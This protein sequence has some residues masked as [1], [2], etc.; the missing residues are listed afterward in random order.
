MSSGKRAAGLSH[1]ELNVSDYRASLKFYGRVLGWLGWERLSCTAQFTAWS[2][3]STKLILCPVE[4]RFKGDAFHRKRVGL[5]HVAFSVSS[6]E[7]V[8]R[9]H[10]EVLVSAAGGAGQCLYGDGPF[11]DEGYYAVYFEDPDRVKL[12]VVHAPRY[13]D[14]EAWP[15]NLPQDFET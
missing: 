7:E 4:E 15:N 11:G 5:N 14:R 10:R 12:E 9:F 2:N 13:F 8:D 1:I 6:R 3:G